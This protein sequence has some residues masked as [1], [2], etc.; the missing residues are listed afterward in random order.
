MGVKKARGNGLRVSWCFAIAACVGSSLVTSS[1][2]LG[3]VQNQSQSQAP[4]AADPASAPPKYEYEV[5]SIKPSKP[6]NA[7]G[8]SPIGVRTSPGGFTASGVPLKIL[9]RMAF[10]AQDNQLEG[11]PSWVDSE[12]YEIDAKMDEA[13]AAAL[14]K[15]S[16]DERSAARRQMLQAL[17]ADRLNL[18]FHMDKKELPIFSLVVGKNGAKLQEAKADNDYANGLKGPNGTPGGAGTM[19]MSFGGDGTTMTAQGVPITTLCNA[20]SQSVGRQVID[21][22]SLTGKYDFTL[23]WMPDSVF[24]GPNGLPGGGGAIAGG[25]GGGAGPAPAAPSSNAPA[26]LD[27]VQ[28]QLGLKLESGKGPADIVVID[29][30]EKP[31][32]N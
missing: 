27:A 23:T 14:Q 9:F 32:Q 24:Q 22:T 15:L 6:G 2:V 3:Q 1:S 25:P 13:T 28:Q 17:L 12:R 4:T 29:H 5:A 11:L 26:L 19:R 30:I 7:D 10:G 31:S 8:S 21:K 16:Q 20:L 18:K